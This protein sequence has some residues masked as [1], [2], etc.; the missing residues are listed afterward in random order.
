[1]VGI[2]NSKELK[3]MNIVSNANTIAAIAR[4][5][6]LTTRKQIETLV[7][8]FYQNQDASA[9]NMAIEATTTIL[10]IALILVPVGLVTLASTNTSALDAQT[11][12]ILGV[13]GVIVVAGIAISLI[14]GSMGGR[15]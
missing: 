9:S 14:K 7:H 15:K 10:V 6:G 2:P 4:A 5:R 1:L 12:T 3:Y 8:E 11:V 13:L